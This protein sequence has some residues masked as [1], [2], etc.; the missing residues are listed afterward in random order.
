MKTS[1]FLTGCFGLALALAFTSGCEQRASSSLAGASSSNNPQAQSDVNSST[2]EKAVLDDQTPAA[3]FSDAPAQPI[4]LEKPLP[5]N[6]NPTGPVSEI[7][8]LADSGLEESVMLA[9]ATNSTSTFNL[10]SDEI[11]Y[12]KDIGVPSSVVTAMI[13]RDE[14]LRQSMANASAVYPPAN[15]GLANEQ[16]QVPGTPCAYP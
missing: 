13:Q 8:K 5:P 2:G 7:V 15:G 1:L 16:G 3:D 9:F 11:V 12:L 6:I 10:S 4:S 14:V